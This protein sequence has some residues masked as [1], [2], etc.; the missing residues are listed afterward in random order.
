MCVSAVRVC[1][2]L[3]TQF[4]LLSQYRMVCMCSK[5]MCVCACVCVFL[6]LS[7][8]LSL[9]LCMCVFQKDDIKYVVSVVCRLFRTLK[10]LRVF[11]GPGGTQFTRFTGTKVQKMTDLFPDSLDERPEGVTLARTRVNF[12]G[13]G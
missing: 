9:S 6:S 12:K 3:H 13:L 10:G 1:T 7:L 4:S 11:R 8:S 5:S 2:Q